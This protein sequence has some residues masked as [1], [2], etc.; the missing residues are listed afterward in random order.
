MRLEIDKL[1]SRHDKNLILKSIFS[2]SS[3]NTKNEPEVIQF[4]KR[5]VYS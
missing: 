1:S 2:V 5:K 3:E 4:Q